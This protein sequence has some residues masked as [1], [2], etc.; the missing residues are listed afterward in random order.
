MEVFRGPIIPEMELFGDV[1]FPTHKHDAA[2]WTDGSVLQPHAA[3]QHSPW[4][5]SY[6]VPQAM[7]REA[8]PSSG[9]DV[10]LARQKHCSHGRSRNCAPQASCCTSAR[11]WAGPFE[12]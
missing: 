8:S 5:R 7:A 9:F 12:D 6:L 2:I 11:T 3:L 10:E 1:S 4:P